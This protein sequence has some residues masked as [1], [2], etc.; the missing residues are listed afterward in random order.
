MKK[1]DL[2]LGTAL[3]FLLLTSNLFG[4]TRAPAPMYKYGDLDH[5]RATETWIESYRSDAAIDGHAIVFIAQ[6]DVRFILEDEGGTHMPDEKTSQMNI[7]IGK[8][9]RNYVV[10]FAGLV[11]F[12]IW[13]NDILALIT[14]IISGSKDASERAQKLIAS[15]ITVVG[16]IAM[17]LLNLGR[18]IDLHNLLDRSLFGVRHKTQIIIHETMIKAAQDAGARGWESMRDKEKEVSYLFFHFVNE[19]K[20]LRDL[21]FTYWEQYFVNIYII[22]I[23][24]LGF[25]ISLIIVLMRGRLDVTAGSPVVFLLIFMVVGLTTRSSLVQKIYD[26]PIQQIEEI[27]TSKANELRAEVEKRFGNVV[28]E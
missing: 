8:R 7:N 17:I 21:A 28:R 16:G 9:I 3:G 2:Y 14:T 10:L 4:Q 6:P 23:A 13:G 27:R 25:V 20:V 12:L 11:L 19:Q 22:S 24:A 18:D 15:V 5:L 1:R 26:L